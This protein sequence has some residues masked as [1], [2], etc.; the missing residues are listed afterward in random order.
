M[1]T[2]PAGFMLRP[3]PLWESFLGPFESGS[4]NVSA[5]LS[6]SPF[7]DSR[8]VGKGRRRRR[9]LPVLLVTFLT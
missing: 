2:E 1:W 6:P 7:Q 5:P 9:A 4:E 8:T 3:L